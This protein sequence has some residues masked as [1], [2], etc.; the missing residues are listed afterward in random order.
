MESRPVATGQRSGSS[1]SLADVLD[2][3][4][5]G[6]RALRGSVVRASGYALGIAIG[7]IAVPFLVRHL[8]VVGFGDYVLVTSLVAVAGGLT[9]GGLSAIGVREYTVR[10]GADR[11]AFMRNLLGLR[12]VLSIAGSSGAV[13]FAL[14]VGY[15]RRLVVGAAL[16]GAGLVLLSLQNLLTAPL[17]AGLRLGWITLVELLRQ[18]A[19]V[20]LT[21]VLVAVGASLVPFFAIPIL[22]GLAAIALT[23]VLV[24]RRM[25]MRPAFDLAQW[26]AMLRDTLPYT[27]ATAI[28]VAYFRIAI[29]VMSLA[30]TG[31]Q[32]GYFATSFRMVEVFIALPSLLVGAVF[33]IFAR[34][35]RDDVERLRYGVRRVFEVSVMIGVWVALAIE[36]GAHAMIAFVGGSKAGPSAA[37]L[38]IQGPALIGTFVAMAC[39]YP[40]LSM[41]RHRVLLFSNLFALLTGATLLAVL[42]PPFQA[43]GAAVATVGAEAALGLSQAIFLVRSDTEL[44]LPVAFLPAVLAAATLAAAVVFVPVNEVVRVA[45]ATVVYFGVLGLLGR[46]PPELRAALVPRRTRASSA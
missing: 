29:I 20:I 17:A 16:A 39:G 33:P 31:L 15:D 42:V 7:L 4:E 1:E 44:R 34:A 9:E 35:A 26:R 24:S 19:T 45:V 14:V 25:P 5:A 40:L 10:S 46:I 12:L 38:Q 8:G 32:T 23:V 18:V 21:L 36:L 41:R 27:A 13:A 28:Y 6:P 22:A 2:T 37:V 43:K 11:D 30:A 3:F